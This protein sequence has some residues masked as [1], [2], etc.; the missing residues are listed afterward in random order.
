MGGCC[1]GG[2]G[3]T[4]GALYRGGAVSVIFCGSVGGCCLGGNGVTHG[5][6]YRGGAVAVIFCGSVGGCCLGDD[7]VTH[8][9]LYC[10]G[11][12]A[13]I[14]CRSV[15]GCCLGDDC[16]THGALYCGGAVAVIFCRSV[17]PQLAI[18]L[19]TDLTGCLSLTG[20]GAAG[21]LAGIV[22]LG[23]FVHYLECIIRKGCAC[24]TAAHAD[25]REDLRSQIPA[26][27]V[28][29]RINRNIIY[30]EC[31]RIGGCTGEV[32]CHQF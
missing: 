18:G 23:L 3:V 9:A 26:K 21:V 15:G 32:F 5:A 25:C 31:D 28:C 20:C 12:V 24:R 16:V 2:N 29:I 30:V 22:L 10:G 17:V 11:A 14:F 27:G 13:V 8:G 19:T 4:Y 7:C 1:L 6:L